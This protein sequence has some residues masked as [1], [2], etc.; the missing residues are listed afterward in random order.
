PGPSSPPT[1][2]PPE[3]SLMTACM[4]CSCRPKIQRRWHRLLIDCCVIP[5]LPGAWEQPPAA[6]PS[7]S[8]VAPPWCDVLRVFTIRSHDHGMATMMSLL[9]G[10]MWL[11]VHRPFE[12]WPALGAIQ[13]ERIYMLLMLLYWAAAARKSW[14][15]NRLHVAL[16]AFAAALG[17]AW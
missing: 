16:A 7:K 10:Y 17:T 9:G 11:F 8:S 1:S 5:A 12:I 3:I 4:A 14:L 15:S 6:G 2:V 13:I